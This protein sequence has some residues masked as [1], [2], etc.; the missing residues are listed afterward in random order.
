MR[1]ARV[2]GVKP[3]RRAFAAHL[4]VRCSKPRSVSNGRASARDMPQR[5]L[6]IMLS[7][8]TG[9]S[10]AAHGHAEDGFQHVGRCMN[11]PSSERTYHVVFS[12]MVYPI[13]LYFVRVC[14]V[15]ARG[16]S[17]SGRFDIDVG[18]SVELRML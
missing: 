11:M 8:Y 16:L 1:C 12:S 18:A 10:W 6:G 13:R 9:R 5:T 17:W 3:Y 14:A 4:S 15:D 7:V 2:D